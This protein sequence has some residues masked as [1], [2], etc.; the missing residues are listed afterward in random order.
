MNR[1]R[2]DARATRH[3]RIPSS[4]ALPSTRLRIPEIWDPVPG[5]FEAVGLDSM[6]KRLPHRT[7]REDR[8]GDQLSKREDSALSLVEKQ[9]VEA[10]AM[11]HTG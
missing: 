5:W 9:H 4:R 3:A 2:V 11:G 7:G 8:S 1:H 10:N 6:A